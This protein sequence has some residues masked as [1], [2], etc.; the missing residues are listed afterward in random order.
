MY[1]CFAAVNGIGSHAIMSRAIRSGASHY[2]LYATVFFYSR[3]ISTFCGLVLIL[4]VGVPVAILDP[5]MAWQH[6]YSPGVAATGI[7]WTLAGICCSPE[8]SARFLG[9]ASKE[10]Q[11]RLLDGAATP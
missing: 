6:P 5:D 4:F 2:E 8:N 11:R 1:L 3:V 9:D 10:R 7:I